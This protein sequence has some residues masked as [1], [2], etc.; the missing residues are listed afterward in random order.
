MEEAR[1]AY[2]S[3][4]IA[5]C[6]TMRLVGLDP[7]AADPSRGG[8][9][10]ESLY[11]SLDTTMSKKKAVKSQEAKEDDLS[12]SGFVNE[13]LS[14]LQALFE[15]EN[16]RMVLLGLPGTGKSTFVRY[17]ALRMAQAEVDRGKNVQELL[18]GWKT[19]AV[20][21]LIIS[22]GRLAESISSDRQRGSTILIENYVEQTLKS[23]ERMVGFA[24]SIFEELER[25]GGLV[26][27]DGLDEV[28]DL[29][30][31]PV[32]VQAVED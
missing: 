2:F 20:L 16:Q 7:Q 17:L 18:P 21:P 4:V 8:L 9:T 11:I 6:R 15:S 31:R 10:L 1:L 24:D 12:F 26:L 13:P 5:D 14:V 23:D 22:L 19:G 29:G 27:F 30:L 3:S 32:V 25:V 28:A